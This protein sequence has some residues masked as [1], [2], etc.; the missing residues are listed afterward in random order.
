M[1]AGRSWF[2]HIIYT[3]RSEHGKHRGIGKR[4][5]EE[6]LHMMSAVNNKREKR[7]AVKNVK[8]D[9]IRDIRSIGSTK[10]TN[11]QMIMLDRPSIEDNQKQVTKNEQIHRNVSGG[12]NHTLI[13]VIVVL[14]IALVIGG[15]IGTALYKKSIVAPPQQVVSGEDTGTE[16]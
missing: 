14:V 5:I 15:F 13:T 10:G 11:L 2:L 6:T 9:Y 3:L 12:W 16:I 4:S 1:S 7:A 8:S